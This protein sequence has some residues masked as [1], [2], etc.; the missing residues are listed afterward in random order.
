VVIISGRDKATIDKWLGELEATLIAEHGAWTKEKG[1]EW[2]C[3]GPLREDWKEAVR[4]ILELYANRT[5][6]A[7]VEEKDFSLVWHCRRADPGL[8]SIRGQELKDHLLNLTANMEVG[9]FE[10]T[11]ILE[12]RHFGIN[13]GRAIKPL[14]EK[15][16]WDFVMA[17]GDDYTDEEMFAVLGE[18]AYSIKV[19]S[20]ASKA[21]FNVDSVQEIRLLL[22][23]LAGEHYG[24]S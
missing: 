23:E 22:K 17:A 9:V 14:L 18:Q 7:L 13:K 16:S 4:P 15:Q 19:G 11:K 24:K 3:I 1:K 5:P 21:R 20:S 2:K 12:V 10:G 8:A 6:G